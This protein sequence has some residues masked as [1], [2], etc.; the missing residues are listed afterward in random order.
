[1]NK[2]A[3]TKEKTKIADVRFV[4][5]HCLFIMMKKIVKSAALIQKK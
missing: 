5:N 2:L 1:M 4:M 3:E